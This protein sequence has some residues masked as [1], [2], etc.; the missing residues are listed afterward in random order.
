MLELSL[1]YKI[2][3]YYLKKKLEKKLTKNNIFVIYQNH[4]SLIKNRTDE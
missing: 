1:K 2:C 4:L 3:L